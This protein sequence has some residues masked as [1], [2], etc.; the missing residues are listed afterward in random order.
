MPDI[1]KRS[2]SP[3]AA[4]ETSALKASA[5]MGQDHEDSTGSAPG[6]KSD[7]CNNDELASDGDGKLH[8]LPLFIVMASLTVMMFVA[9]LDM[10]ILGTVS[11]L[12]NHWQ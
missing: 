3:S 1:E 10:S 2:Q 4:S 9:M 7:S 6:D 8:G 12:R 11:S 5:V